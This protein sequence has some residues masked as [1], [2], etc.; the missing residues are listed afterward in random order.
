MILNIHMPYTSG[1]VVMFSQAK[2]PGHT[3]AQGLCVRAWELEYMSDIDMRF[4]VASFNAH[5]PEHLM[6][7]IAADSMSAADVRALRQRRADSF[8]W[9]A[10]AIAAGWRYGHMGAQQV[11][12]V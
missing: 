10:V 1:I 3:E 6:V 12:S 2:P 11:E 8:D 4:G 9:Q 5:L 7:R